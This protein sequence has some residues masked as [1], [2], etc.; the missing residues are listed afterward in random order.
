MK[1]AGNASFGELS[2]KYNLFAPKHD[3][4]R[5]A[6]NSHYEIYHPINAIDAQNNAPIHFLV[7]GTQD[8]INFDGTFLKIEGKFTGQI[9][10]VTGANAA[11]AI[12][13]TDA[14]AKY[15]PVNLLAHTMFKSIDIS[16]NGTSISLADQNYMYRAYLQTL[17]NNTKSGLD[18]THAL[19][20]WS[21]D[22]PEH[23]DSFEP[24]NN[25]SLKARRGRSNAKGEVT[26]I[27]KLASAIFEIEELFPSKVDINVTLHKN[28]NSSFYMMFD[29][30]INGTNFNFEITKVEMWVHKITVDSDFGLGVEQV[31]N[32]NHSIEYILSDPRVDVHQIPSGV[33][34]FHKDHITYGHLPRRLLI[35]FL[36]TEA[37]NG[38]SKKNPFNFKHFDVK[39]ISLFKDGMEFPRPPIICDMTDKKYTEA[40]YHLLST[41]HANETPFAMDIS[42]TDLENGF[43]FAAWEFSPDQM[44]GDLPAMLINEGTNIHLTVEFGTNLPS[45]VSMIVYYELDMRVS[46][47]QYRQ[48]TVENN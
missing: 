14:D 36:E 35:G 42:E 25:T 22:L 21:K 10:A 17:F 39:K 8:F 24:A 16:L 43:F 9:P 3:I 37:F 30:A 45:P 15:G 34:S 1:N 20:G 13:A 40:Y 26:Y 11:A 23:M 32:E 33:P 28:P 4:S 29:N 46:I 27:L 18:K 5:V 6:K 44:G 12:P 31:M 47:N 48:V 38:A 7:R 19:A 2:R 41:F